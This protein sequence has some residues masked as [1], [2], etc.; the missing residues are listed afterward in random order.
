LGLAGG[1]EAAEHPVTAVAPIAAMMAPAPASTRGR[2]ACPGLRAAIA[3]G[4]AASFISCSLP[5][6]A[7]GGAGGSPH[8]AVGRHT[9]SGGRGRLPWTKVGV[10][11]TARANNFPG[12][13]PRR[14]GDGP[15]PLRRL[16][17]RRGWAGEEPRDHGSGAV[18]PR[19]SHDPEALSCTV[20]YRLSGSWERGAS[21]VGLRLGGFQGL[22]GQLVAAASSFCST[23]SPSIAIW[24]SSLTTS[25][26]SRTALK[27]RPNSFLLIL[28]VAP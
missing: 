16:P 7:G 12:R 15:H 23:S 25:L 14:G 24:I 3:G 17:A 1:A 5:R 21:A 27:L 13:F 4:A 11:A 20:R 10:P 19:Y 18:H 8:R 9:A 6:P 2:A 26:P 28:V 22:R